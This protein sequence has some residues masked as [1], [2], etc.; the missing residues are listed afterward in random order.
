MGKKSKKLVKD[1]VLG[2]VAASIAPKSAEDKALEA[3]YKATIPVVS[4][5]VRVNA[6]NVAAEAAETTVEIIARIEAR[7]NSRIEDTAD[8]KERKKLIRRRNDI[9]GAAENLVKTML[10]T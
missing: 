6:A 10:T 5:N 2:I 1:G 7:Y 3:G 8:D 4:Q 9:V